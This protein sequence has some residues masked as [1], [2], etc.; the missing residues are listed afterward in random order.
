MNEVHPKIF[1]D[2]DVLKI[3]T[4][5]HKDISSFKEE[6]DKRYY[7]ED[8]D[9]LDTSCATCEVSFVNNTDKHND[10]VYVS[11]VNNPDFSILVDGNLIVRMCIS[12]CV[13][14]NH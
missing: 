6:T 14:Q 13:I 2:E 5:N 9:L 10:P 11:Y 12:G 3:Y 4:C 8:G 7:Q 1:Q